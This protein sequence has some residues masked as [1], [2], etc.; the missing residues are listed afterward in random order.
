MKLAIRSVFLFGLSA[1]CLPG[2]DALKYQKPSK[3]ILDVLTAP[4]TPTL[5]LNPNHTYAIESQ[6]LRNPPI[7]ELSQPMLRLAGLRI[8]PKNNGLHNIFYSSSIALRKVPEGTLVKIATPAGARLSAPRWSPDATRFAFTNITDTAIEL[9]IGDTTGHAHRIEGVHVNG[10]MGSPG[11]FGGGGGRGGAGP[12]S[13]ELQWMPDGRNLL[14]EIVP[15][16]GPAPADPAV[17]EGPHVQESLGTAHGSAT[18]ED[19]LQNPHDEDLFE[20]YATSQLALV[21]PATAKV[22]P[23]G[24]PAIFES[25]RISPDG[26]NLLVTTVHRPFSYLLSVE[27]FPREIRKSGIAPGKMLPQ[28]HQP[29]SGGKRFAHRRSH[30][31]ARHPVAAK[32]AIHA[33]VGGSARW[34]QPE[35]SGALP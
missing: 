21:D 5:A 26:N 14:V 1:L 28:S 27:S 30:R 6:A 19:M 12:V 8:N 33:V 13:S 23:I 24:K 20:Y 2:A 18:L 7:A 29:A 15:R 9:W 34:R 32:R 22:T 31:S 17:P 10:V 35:E 11:S 16:H 25:V 4:P 3:A